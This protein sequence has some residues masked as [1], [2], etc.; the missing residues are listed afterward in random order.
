MFWMH[1]LLKIVIHTH[2]N[3]HVHKKHVMTIKSFYEVIN[4]NK[5]IIIT[6]TKTL[7]LLHYYHNIYFV[8]II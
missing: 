8:K 6:T 7:N 4:V 2:K 5:I 3:S 1:F